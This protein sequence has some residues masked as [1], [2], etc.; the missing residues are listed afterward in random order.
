MAPRPGE[1]IRFIGRSSRRIAVSV[2]GSVFVVGGVVMLALPGPGIVV[3]VIGFAI[4][5][6]E[7]TWAAVALEHSKRTAT[8][9]SQ[10]ARGSVKGA[11]K[12]ANKAVR[13][14][15]RRVTRR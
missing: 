4:L 3:I 6:T 12:G 10:I 14:T 1:I 11:A 13:S 9:A 15:G 2:V 8:K 5:G 7:Y